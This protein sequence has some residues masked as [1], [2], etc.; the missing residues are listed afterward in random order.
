MG[1]CPPELSIFGRF[2]NSIFPMR[3]GV[4]YWIKE[5]DECEQTVNVS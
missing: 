5:A 2:T 3:Q 1:C 4:S